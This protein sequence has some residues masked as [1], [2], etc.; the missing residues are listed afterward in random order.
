MLRRGP[1][2][3]G[4]PM[5]KPSPIEPVPEG[6]ARIARAAFRKGNPLLK[7]RDELG[8]IFADADF[9]DL[10]PKL[11]QPGLRPW[12]PARA[13][14]PHA[15]PA[16]PAA[17]APGA[18]HRPPV[19]GEP[20]RPPG[21]RGG[22][23]ADRLEVPPGPRARRSRLRPLGAVRVPL[24]SPGR[25][26]RGAALGQAAGGVPGARSA[27]GARAAAD[28]LDP[29]AGLD[30]GPEPARAGRRDPAGGPERAGPGRAGP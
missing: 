19:P 24:T 18:G 26:R 7:L 9:A 27:Q 13:P 15:R 14:V 5:L 25:R 10:F 4:P 28:R 17:L 2:A 23:G 22:P 3:R 20:A 12:R 29:G 11:G 8:A 16:G 21:G 6:T 30:P 1:P